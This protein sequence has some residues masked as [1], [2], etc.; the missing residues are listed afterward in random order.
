VHLERE[1]PARARYMIPPHVRELVKP[2]GL[3]K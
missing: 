3:S 2:Y 1:E